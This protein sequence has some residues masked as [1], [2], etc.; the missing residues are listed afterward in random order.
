MRDFDKALADILAIKGQM[1]AGTAFRGY[2]PATMALTGLLALATATLQA[3]LLAD[4]GAHPLAFFGGWIATAL[5][6]AAI[7]GT[8]MVARSRR[9]H[10]G[11][12]DA[13]IRQAVEQFLPAAAAGAALA[14]VIWRFAPDA[15]WMVPGL[16]QLLMGL[17]IFASLRTLP[18]GV[19]LAAGWYVLAGLTVLMLDSE[20]RALSPWSMGLPFAIGQC[21]TA[22]ILRLASE[23]SDG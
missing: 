21:L 16:W 11:L 20:T 19:A 8:E 3:L 9:H 14:L 17:G 6:A 1:A 15:S 13:M 12:A 23:P 10:L 4:P 22:A 5:A 2:G 18:R 7:T